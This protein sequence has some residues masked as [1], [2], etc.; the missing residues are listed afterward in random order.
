MNSKQNKKVY[1]T[2]KKAGAVAS[3]PSRI[4]IVINPDYQNYASFYPR[5]YAYLLAPEPDIIGKL[6]VTFF[7]HLY[8]V[9][10]HNYDEKKISDSE[11]NPV[12]RIYYPDYARSIG[13]SSRINKS[14]VKRFINKIL[15][16]KD[17]LGFIDGA[18]LPALIF[19]GEDEDTNTVRIS[20]PYIM[21]LIRRLSIT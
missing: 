8:A 18:V 4:A 14:E 3:F 5:G 6:D 12:L 10:L 9:F 21:A 20:S 2:R 19:E 17:V 11:L 16:F 13:K 1:R 7:R 15:S